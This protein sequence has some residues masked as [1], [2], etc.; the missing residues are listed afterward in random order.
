M[1]YEII[2]HLIVVVLC[3]LLALSK[4]RNAELREQLAEQRRATEAMFLAAANRR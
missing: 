1:V 3:V 2:Q 4:H